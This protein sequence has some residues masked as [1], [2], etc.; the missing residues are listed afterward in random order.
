MLAACRRCRRRPAAEDPWRELTMTTVPL[1]GDRERP[2]EASAGKPELVHPPPR[3]I[4]RRGPDDRQA[5]RLHPRAGLRLRRQARKHHEIYLS[6]PQRSA[7]EKW[8]T[9]IRQPFSRAST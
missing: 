7:P 2:Y 6:D 5:P 4:H 1:T 8:R 9:I 3:A